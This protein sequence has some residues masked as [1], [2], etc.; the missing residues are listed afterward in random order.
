MVKN[1]MNS[2]LKCSCAGDQHPRFRTSFAR[3]QSGSFGHC[4][5][6]PIGGVGVANK[7]C[8]PGEF[9]EKLVACFSFCVLM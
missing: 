8:T 4:F 9:G 2:G 3:R 7:R 6:V 1:P 5:F